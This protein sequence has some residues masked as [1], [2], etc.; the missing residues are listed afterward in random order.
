MSQVN[1]QINAKA[2]DAMSPDASPGTLGSGVRRVNNLP[3]YILGGVVGTF[4]LVM[5]VVASSRAAKQDAPSD[6]A[7]IKAVSANTL[8]EQIVSEQTGA[9]VPPAA[10][11]APAK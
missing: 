2:S 11:A 7:P 1:A 10:T 4:L 5:T 6:R 9:W 3:V 8:A